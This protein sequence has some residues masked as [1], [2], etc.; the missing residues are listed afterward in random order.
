M[1][2]DIKLLHPEVQAIIPKFL[3]ECKKQGLIVKTTDTVRTKEEQNK[4]YAQGLLGNFWGLL[5]SPPRLLPEMQ[6][7]KV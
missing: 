3:E 7:F 4:L 5:F 1:S 2:R 6:F